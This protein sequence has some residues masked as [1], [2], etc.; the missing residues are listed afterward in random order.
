MHVQ[1]IRGPKFPIS[2]SLHSIKHNTYQI[3]NQFSFIKVTILYSTNK[4]SNSF[5]WINNV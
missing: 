1:H 3:L 4:I 5:I 2:A